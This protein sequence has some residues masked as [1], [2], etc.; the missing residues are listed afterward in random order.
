VRDIGQG[1]YGKATLVQD[2]EGKLYVMKTIDMSSM[3]KKQRRDAINEVRVLSFLKHPYIVSYRESFSE[4]STLAIVM[5][6]AD[7]GDLYQRI[8]LTRKAGATFIERQ[9]LRWF[10]EAAL[11]L[12]YMHDKHVL[13][14]DL[15][16]QNLF[17]TSSDRLRVGDFGISKVLENT[18]AF[19]RTAIGTPYYLSPEICQEKPY[20]FGS[21]VWALGCVLYEMAALKVPFDAQNLQALVQKIVR[22]PMPPVPTAY[23]AECRQL[24]W[25]L[26]H[27][28]QTQRPTATDI[29]QRRYVQDEIRRMLFEERSKAAQQGPSS[30]QP[31]DVPSQPGSSH[32][33]HAGVRKPA[34]YQAPAADPRV[35]GRRDAGGGRSAF[36]PSR[37]PQAGQAAVQYPSRAASP[38][39]HRRFA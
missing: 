25:D 8:G 33:S 4:S 29:I 37:A 19:A 18:A 36:S 27:R 11:A 13:H 35:D 26:L 34:A 6:Y 28:D 24:C 38:G 9:I 10:T 3:D 2:H 1:S 31:N 15:K 14:R 7:G 23:S 30:Q 22:G 21:D 32:A 16:S 20:S 39:S 12:K 5:D 17:L